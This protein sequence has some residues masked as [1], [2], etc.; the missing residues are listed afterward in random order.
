MSLNTSTMH[1]LRFFLWLDSG[2]RFW[3][4]RPQRESTISSHYIEGTYYQDVSLL[5]L[6]LVI[7]PRWSGFFTPK[8]FLI[9]SFPQCTLWKEITSPSPYLRSVEFCPT[10]LR[11]K[12][13][14][15]LFEILLHQ[16]FLCS[17]S[18]IYVFNHTFISIW[19][20]S[21]FFNNWC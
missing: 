12:C 8:P 9:T 16:R 15:K 5:V 10:S 6:T 3:G 11:A 2:Y 17:L 19:T 21:L 20:M 1:C 4:K 13:L 14:Q 7:W 18:F